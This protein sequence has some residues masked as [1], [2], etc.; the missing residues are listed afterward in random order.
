M[1]GTASAS[2]RRACPAK[3]SC[4]FGS[5]AAVRLA[6]SGADSAGVSASFKL[7]LRS[8]TGAPRDA[9]RD[10]CLTG[11]ATALPRGSP[12]AEAATEGSAGADDAPAL[13]GCGPAAGGATS[14]AGLGCASSIRVIV[15]TAGAVAAGVATADTV[16]VE[17]T[18]ATRDSRVL[19]EGGSPGPGPPRNQAGGSRLAQDACTR[20]A[21]VGL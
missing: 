19:T 10:G 9:L 5:T 18:R 13:T 14:S 3:S 17:A 6:G 20:G 16:S 4:A 21:C 11:D 2:V 12:A 7:S 15:A 1:R 8:S